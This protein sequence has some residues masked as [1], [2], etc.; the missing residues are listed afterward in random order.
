MKLFQ[1]LIQKNIVDKFGVIKTFITFC[2]V[3]WYS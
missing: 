2:G 3:P 1:M